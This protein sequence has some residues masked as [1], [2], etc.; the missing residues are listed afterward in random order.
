MRRAKARAEGRSEPVDYGT[1]VSRWR[2]IRE[3]ERCSKRVA[4]SLARVERSR[5]RAARRKRRAPETTYVEV[6]RTPVEP[7]VAVAPVKK[8]LR[9]RRR[10]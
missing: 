8:R 9:L 3:R 1:P 7:A 4:K 6:S 5:E 10:G 2:M